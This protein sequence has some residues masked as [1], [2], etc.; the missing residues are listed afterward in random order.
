MIIREAGPASVPRAEL[1]HHP[2]LRHDTRDWS[3]A[4]LLTKLKFGR[5]PRRRLVFPDTYLFCAAA[6]VFLVL[7]Q[8]AQNMRHELERAWAAPARLASTPRRT[9]R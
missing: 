2:A 9:K 1:D 4:E 6:A 5:P 7:R 3:E 8:A